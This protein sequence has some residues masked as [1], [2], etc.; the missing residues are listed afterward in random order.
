MNRRTIVLTTVVVLLGVVGAAAGIMVDRVRGPQWSAETGILLR[1]SSPDMLLMTGLPT[2]V[3]VEDLIDASALA[4]SQ[5][6]LARAAGKLGPP[7]TWSTL[8]KRVTVEPVGTSHIIKITAK[9]PTRDQASRAAD[10][11]ADAYLEATAEQLRATTN[12]LQTVP[13][14]PDPGRQGG[15]DVTADVRSR[16]VVL[17]NGV[18]VAQVLRTDEPTQLTPSIMTP[19]TLGIVGLAAGALAAVAVTV[20]RPGGG[21]RRRRGA[22]FTVPAVGTPPSLTGKTPARFDDATDPAAR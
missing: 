18:T 14:P 19:I 17:A 3:G 11:V 7:V 12:A 6:V 2:S 8:A 16:A 1:L 15:S 9:Y 13:R 22:T 4:K 10:A 5:D 21:S 20:L